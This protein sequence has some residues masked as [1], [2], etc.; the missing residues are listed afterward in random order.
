M[1]NKY[2]KQQFESLLDESLV[3]L[4]QGRGVSADDAYG[5]LIQRHQPD[6]LRRCQARLGNRAD[7]EEAVQETLVRVFR[8]LF[9]FRGDA[10]FR[11]WLFSIADNQCNTVY[12]RRS[13]LVM[14]EHVRALI[15]LHQG[16]SHAGP[17]EDDAASVEE[18]R[19]SLAHLPAP[20]RDV[21][22]LRF[23]GDLSL[24][25]IADTLGIGLSAAKM[26][27][28]RAMS[29]FETVFEATDLAEVA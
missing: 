9:R 13:R 21:L 8:G 3:A 22:T 25:E 23:Y 15:E 17:E 10:A 4:F 2:E 28:Y 6:L 14:S 24:E 26:R 29:Q 5:V 20:A 1:K 11:T 16:L 18:V 7:A 27:L 12:Q 19:R